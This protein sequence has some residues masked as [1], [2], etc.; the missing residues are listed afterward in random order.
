MN[1]SLK[2]LLSQFSQKHL[3]VV[4]DVMLDKYL[5]GTVNRISPEAPVPVVDITK[6]EYH[7]GGAANVAQNIHGLDA[8]VTLIGIIGDDEDGELLKSVISKDSRLDF[9]SVIQE[10]RQTTVKTRIMAQGQQ[11][12]RLDHENTDSLK[13]ETYIQLKKL[14]KSSLIDVDGIILQDYE[15]GVFSKELIQWLMKI[16]KEYSLPVY[17]DPKDNNYVEFSGARLLKPNRSEFYK[18]VDSDQD[19]LIS[20]ES[21]RVDN[22][23]DILLVTL[24]EKGMAIFSE[25]DQKQISTQARSVN[26]VSGAGD[27]VIATFALSDLCGSS[28]FDSALLANHAAGRVCEEVGVVPIN[29]KIL[30]EMVAEHLD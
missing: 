12:L 20:A 11:I 23:Y 27:T 29:S 16:S 25:D 21:L 18:N 30:S 9:K 2:E 4:G 13:S 5:W 14:V 24:G 1:L 19:I 28:P 3:L 7:A 10:K 15:K 26:D 6:T 8:K 17:V 22:N